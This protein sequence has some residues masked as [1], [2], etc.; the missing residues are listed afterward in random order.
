MAK[1]LRVELQASYRLMSKPADGQ[2]EAERAKLPFTNLGAA[3]G[4]AGTKDDF[5]DS[6]ALAPSGIV[7]IDLTALGTI[8]YLM[9]VGDGAGAGFSVTFGAGAPKSCKSLFVSDGP[10]PSAS[11]VLTNLDASNAVNISLA[12]VGH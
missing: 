10:T 4:V 8:D 12:A 3:I 9:L 1:T 2:P 11:M 6:I 5:R 7:T